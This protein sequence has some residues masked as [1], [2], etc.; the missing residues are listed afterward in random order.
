[1][2]IKWSTMREYVRTS[3]L[4]DVVVVEGDTVNADQFTDEQLLIAA[5][6]ACVSL[7][8]HTAQKSLRVFQCNGTDYL[9]HLDDNVVDG[10][11]KTALVIYDDG[12][13]LEYLAPIRLIPSTQWPTTP[14]GSDSSGAR[15]FWEWPDDTVSMSFIPKSGSR[16]Q[17]KYFKVWNPPS[18][19]DDILE[20]PIQFE[21]P[22]AYLIG[23]SAFDPLGAQ[24]SAIRTWNR[25]SDSG[26]PEDNSLQKQ[27]EY[28]LK[29]AYMRLK[30]IGAQDRET[31]YRLES[32][33]FGYKT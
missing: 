23:A 7:S 6:W 29:M 10:L 14:P 15:G 18:S 12:T 13:C 2:S 1:M 9:F 25:K 26:T 19:D 33:D 22:F 11:E 4:K 3:I 16:L 32:R 21:Q 30:D 27:S 5:R 24:A 28:F 17:V 8:M 20:F 31:F